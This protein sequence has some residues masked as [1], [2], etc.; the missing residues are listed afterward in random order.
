M[1]MPE[2]SPR[3]KNSAVAKVYPFL[4]AETPAYLIG[5]KTG[6]HGTKLI[7]AIRGNYRLGYVTPPPP[8]VRRAQH[9]INTSA[10]RGGILLSIWPYLELDLTARQ[11]QVALLTNE[12]ES[13][14]QEQIRQAYA[15]EVRRHNLLRPIDELTVDAQRDK[16]RTDNELLEIVHNRQA[17]HEHLRRLRLPKPQTLREWK[18]FEVLFTRYPVSKFEDGQAQ[19][20]FVGEENINGLDY[21]KVVFKQRLQPYLTHLIP[22]RK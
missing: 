17:T 8:E 2:K 7:D 11:T 15:R 20:L 16:R 10:S 5:E 3:R 22:E 14:S 4:I 18:I 13:F 9:R 21:I 12:G 6:L 1:E 19:I